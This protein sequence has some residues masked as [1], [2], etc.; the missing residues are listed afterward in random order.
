MVWRTIPGR[1]LAPFHCWIRHLPLPGT[2]HTGCAPSACVGSPGVS[3]CGD[4]RLGEG[5]EPAPSRSLGGVSEDGLFSAEE[6]RPRPPLSCSRSSPP[7]K[8][9][10]PWEVCPQALSLVRTG[11]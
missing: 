9:S 4:A 6:S 5:P 11:P 10:H 3:V 2:V 1:V 8:P 7:P